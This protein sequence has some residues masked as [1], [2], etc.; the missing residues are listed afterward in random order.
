MHDYIIAIY[1]YT[2]TDN[3]YK[4]C[5][6]ICYITHGIKYIAVYVLLQHGYIVLTDTH[7]ML[8]NTLRNNLCS[9]LIF[10]Y[11]QEFN[12]T[13]LLHNIKYTQSEH[14]TYTLI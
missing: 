8:Y 2:Y 11:N 7:N 1:I 12:K 13:I 4:I 9:G 5:S 6:I 14:N 10:Q 3:T